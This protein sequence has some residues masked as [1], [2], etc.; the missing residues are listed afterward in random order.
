M[1]TTAVAQIYTYFVLTT[2]VAVIILALYIIY[3][4]ACVVVEL[5]YCGVLSLKTQG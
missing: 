5:L 4:A 3:T 2:A 1:W